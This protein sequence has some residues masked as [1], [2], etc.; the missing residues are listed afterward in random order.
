[1]ETTKNEMP[2]Y[3]NTFFNKLKNYL[4][5][6]LYFFGSVQRDDY[7]PNSSDIDVM[8]F[9]DNIKSVV[10]KIQSFLNNNLG[11][12]AE[13]KKFI[14]KSNNTNELVNGFK[15]IYEEP[16]NNFSTEF[17]IYDEKHKEYILNVKQRQIFL[18]FYA[19]WLLIIVKFFYYTLGVLPKDWFKYLKDIIL[20]DLISVKSEDYVAL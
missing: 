10:T 13:L 19:S 1:M 18:P 15:I 2:Q 6:P 9:T 12:I 20:H 5:T 4:D 8:I 11:N 14:I 16:E 7:L 3:N 17:S